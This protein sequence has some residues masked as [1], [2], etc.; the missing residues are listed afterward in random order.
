VDAYVAAV[1]AGLLLHV[2]SHDLHDVPS[3]RASPSGLKLAAALFGVS[4]GVIGA[5][6][7]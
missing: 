1:V 7:H 2:V 6:L 5:L 3:Q 4:V